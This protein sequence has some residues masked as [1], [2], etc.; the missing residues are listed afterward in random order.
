MSINHFFSNTNDYDVQLGE[1]RKVYERRNSFSSEDI[2]ELFQKLEHIVQH[3]PI[4]VTVDKAAHYILDLHQYITS[5][6]GDAPS[7]HLLVLLQTSRVSRAIRL[8]AAQKIS[9][10]STRMLYEAEQILLH[11]RPDELPK[12]HADAECYIMEQ[13]TIA[14][15]H[16]LA[17]VLMCGTLTDHRVTCGRLLS[18]YLTDTTSPNTRAST[19]NV[20]VYYLKQ[21]LRDSD[22][23][24][25]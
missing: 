12:E 20:L 13:I 21:S 4:G 3:A 2:Q 17:T 24:P 9:K 6:R 7:S 22:T 10:S 11:V 8:K 14:R 5:S 25:Q 18:D 19:Y 23:K 16:T 1:I 15:P